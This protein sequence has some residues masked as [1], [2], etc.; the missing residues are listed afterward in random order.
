MSIPGAGPRRLLEEARSSPA[1]GPDHPYRSSGCIVGRELHADL[2][3]PRPLRSSRRLW[4]R[5]RRRHH[6][7]G[8]GRAQVRGFL[9]QVRAAG[10]R[11][12]GHLAGRSAAPEEPASPGGG[13]RGKGGQ[14]GARRGAQ[15]WG[16]AAPREVDTSSQVSSW[17]WGLT[18]Y[19]YTED[20]DTGRGWGPRTCLG[21]EPHWAGA[22]WGPAGPEAVL[23]QGSARWSEHSPGPE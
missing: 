3:K 4:R 16:T 8:S 14:L 19:V 1:A 10:M 18:A 17:R 12:S 20:S 13:P 6:P 22:S 15:R 11:S 9:H 7:R 21:L 5:L 23:D 2:V